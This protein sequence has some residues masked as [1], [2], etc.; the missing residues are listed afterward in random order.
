MVVAAE[1]GPKLERA[2]WPFSDEL[3]PRAVAAE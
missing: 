3:L 2:L 1:T